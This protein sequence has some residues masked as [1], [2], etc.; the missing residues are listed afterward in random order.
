LNGQGLIDLARSHF[1]TVPAFWGRYFTSPETT[2]SVEYHH[3]LEGAALNASGIRVLPVARQ[4]THVNGTADEGAADAAAN[5]ADFLA[6]FGASYLVT[7]GNVFYMFLDVEGSPSLSADYYTGWA[8]ALAASSNSA[9]GGAVTLRPCLYAEPK[10]APT[11]AALKQAMANG[12]DCGGAWV[13]RYLNDGCTRFPDWNDAFVTPDGGAPCPILLWQYAG[14]CYGNGGIDCS[15]TNPALD[16]NETLLKF[17][18][19]P[20][21]AS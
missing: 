17:L 13:A 4:T 2:G 21:A 3:A 9:T 7:L 10:D 16:P 15:Q 8:Q 20:P 5:A 1:G 12:A 11:W 18:A 14:N 19:L 6:S